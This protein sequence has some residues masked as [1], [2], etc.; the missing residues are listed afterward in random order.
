MT[1]ALHPHRYDSHKV[2]TY[3]W[4]TLE[5]VKLELVSEA[6]MKTD[7]GS[8]EEKGLL[9][10]GSNISKDLEAGVLEQIE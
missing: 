3:L 9:G 8:R 6:W 5:V 2:S 7:R 4:S 1:P 10:R